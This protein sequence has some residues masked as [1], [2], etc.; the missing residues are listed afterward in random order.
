M[1]ETRFHLQTAI[2]IAR[3]AGQLLRE[4]MGRANRVTRKGRIDLV[5]EA[6][7]ASEELITKGLWRTLPHHS[8]VAEEGTFRN[9]SA[10]YIWYIDPL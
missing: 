9:T 5:T 2:R 10:D 3:Q 8:V 7:R 6:D 4:R 1:E